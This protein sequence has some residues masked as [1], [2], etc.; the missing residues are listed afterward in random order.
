MSFHVLERFWCFFTGA[1]NGGRRCKRQS[2]RNEVKGVWR[3]IWVGIDCVPDVSCWILLRQGLPSPHS[4]NACF[5]WHVKAKWDLSFSGKPYRH[6]AEISFAPP[7]LDLT[8]PDGPGYRR[9]Y[10][11][12]R[13]IVDMEDGIDVGLLKE[14]KKRICHCD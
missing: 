3:R 7:H 9:G 13:V 12:R 2:G 14:D 5:P 10:G 11:S 4:V 1:S 6:I 8:G